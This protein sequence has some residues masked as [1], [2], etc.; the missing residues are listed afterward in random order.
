MSRPSCS[1]GE[2]GMILS[3]QA[4]MASVR[5]LVRRP[6]TTTVAWDAVSLLCSGAAGGETHDQTGRNRL[7]AFHA[8]LRFLFAPFH[9]CTILDIDKLKLP[10]PAPTFPH[11]FAREPTA[12]KTKNTPDHEGRRRAGQ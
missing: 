11:P 8:L 3:R 10:Y 1:V 2:A 7:I 12:G 9:R 5:D 6:G 4:S